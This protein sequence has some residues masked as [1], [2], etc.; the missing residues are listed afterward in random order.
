MQTHLNNILLALADPSIKIVVIKG[1][2]GSGKTSFIPLVCQSVANVVVL[3]FANKAV[4][5]LHSKG[6]S[7]ART[8]HSSLF[9]MLDTGRKKTVQKPVLDPLTC[10]PMVDPNNSSGFLYN[11]IEEPIFTQTFSQQALK[12]RKLIHEDASFE[13]VVLLIDEASM[14]NSEI[15][16]NLI[17]NF[18][19]KIIA[20]GDPNQ[21]PPVEADRE[22]IVYDYVNFFN[23][24]PATI[25][26]TTI[27]RQDANSEILTIANHFLAT[28]KDATVI[29]IPHI[30]TDDVVSTSADSDKPFSDW[31]Y[32]NLHTYDIVISQLNETVSKINSRI[33]N[34]KFATEFQNLPAAKRMIPR[35]GERLY[36]E[37]SFEHEFNIKFDENGEKESSES[38]KLFKGQFIIIQDFLGLDSINNLAVIN[39]V[40]ENG[41]V[42]ECLPIK[43]NFIGLNTK[44]K[45]AGVRV[46]WGY[47]ITCH[48]AQG[49]QWEN[50]L[51]IDTRFFE[52]LPSNP[53]PEDWSKFH[54]RKPF[55]Y[56]A[57]T[58]ASRELVLVSWN[59]FLSL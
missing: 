28:K 15:W 12:T 47:A 5:V 59:K 6:I 14:V 40:D 32:D 54:G 10:K 52:R 13:N 41:Y 3:A 37:G 50:V 34:L 17:E 24:A 11:E 21:L 55:L 30:C 19:G 18:D 42:W 49:S 1:P 2:A 44:P 20:I 45:I 23:R 22:K 38:K 16:Y 56:T 29:S 4:N 33:R 58:R 43:L 27:H 35:V 57:V 8:I 51:V 9:E 48:K 26:L 53:T 36:V 39:A 46:C 25:T 7:K 31:L